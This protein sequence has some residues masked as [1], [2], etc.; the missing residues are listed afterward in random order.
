MHDGGD[1]NNQNNNGGAVADRLMRKKVETEI[2][3]K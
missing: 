1:I 2:K 3:I